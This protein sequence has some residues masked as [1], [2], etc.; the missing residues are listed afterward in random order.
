MDFTLDDDQRSFRDSLER[1]LTKEDPVAATRAWAVG[2]HAPGLG[3]WRRVAGV[4]VTALA[5][6]EGGLGPLPLELTI[7]HESIGRH[8]V[9]GPWLEHAFVT[10]LLSTVPDLD[11]WADLERDM[12]ARS[13]VFTAA[14]PPR[15]PY[16]L[17]ADAA[18]RVYLVA[19]GHLHTAHVGEL[20]RS[21]DPARRL[22]P[23]TAQSRV[24]TVPDAALASAS[25]LTVLACAAQLLGLGEAL[26]ERSVD[27]VKQRKQF[28]RP[29]GE[30]QALKHALADVRIG[31]DFTRPLVHGAALSYG[32]AEWPRDVSAAKVKA[33]DSAYRAART[34]LQVHGA[35]GYT[36]E[37]DLSLWLL[38]VRALVAA[39]GT[40]TEHRARLLSSLTR[41]A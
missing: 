8:A 36:A 29:I 39:W 38:K 19:D 25:D 11:G 17:D 7:A 37:H 28:G 5:L 33:A 4:G 3:L 24:G 34:A 14:V 32:S 21:V 1:L 41:G 20:V 16:A 12:I 31:L 27:Y 6:R 35:I 10:A 23:V 15:V 22:F 13:L 40:T 9:P 2:D 18:D 30:Y 26:L